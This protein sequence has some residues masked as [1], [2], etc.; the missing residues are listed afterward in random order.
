MMFELSQSEEVKI[1]L[2]KESLPDVD[3]DVGGKKYCY[4]YVF[5]PTGLG[6]CKVVRRTADG[7]EFDLTNYELW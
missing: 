4:E 2:W 6:I 3:Y 5:Y 1:K 7:A